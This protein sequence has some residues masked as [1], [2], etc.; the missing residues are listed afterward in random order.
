MAS[1]N[2]QYFFLLNIEIKINDIEVMPIDCEV[3]IHKQF[4]GQNQSV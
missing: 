4:K 1:A 2:G 3:N